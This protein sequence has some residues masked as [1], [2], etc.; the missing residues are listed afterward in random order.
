MA[1]PRRAAQRRAAQAYRSRSPPGG[2]QG[3]PSRPSARGRD[4]LARTPQANGG[5]EQSVHAIHA[6]PDG[7]RFEQLLRELLRPAAAPSTG[8][9][10][11]LEVSSVDLQAPP[12]PHQE[13]FGFPHCSIAG[14]PINLPKAVGKPHRDEAAPAPAAT[15]PAKDPARACPPAEC[16]GGTTCRP[17]SAKASADSGPDSR[18]VL[19][20]SRKPSGASARP[21][22]RARKQP[23]G[24]RAGPAGAE[25]AGER[26]PRPVTPQPAPSQPRLCEPSTCPAS[27]SSAKPRREVA[28]D[29]HPQEFQRRGVV[30]R[31]VGGG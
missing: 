20:P 11:Q 31:V 1:T 25:E 18:A 4:N 26:A 9:A 16:K 3:R 30:L 14:E 6:W 12:A 21:T 2:D 17:R 5:D 13:T 29:V 10:Q 27:S 22:H 7:L 23:V 19:H 15:N 24:S 8:P 28:A